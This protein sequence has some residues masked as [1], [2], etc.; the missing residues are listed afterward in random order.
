MTLLIGVAA[1]SWDTGPRLLADH[2]QVRNRPRLQLEK[3]ILDPIEVASLELTRDPL[4]IAL[5]PPGPSRRHSPR[6][7]VPTAYTTHVESSHLHWIRD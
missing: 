2:A 7:W 3:S 4:E 1:V 6:G 5:H